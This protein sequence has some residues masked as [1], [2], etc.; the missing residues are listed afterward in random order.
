MKRND[1]LVAVNGRLILDVCA[2]NW[3]LYLIG[4]LFLVAII[5]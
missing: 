2:P 5:K 3:F 4:V 1:I